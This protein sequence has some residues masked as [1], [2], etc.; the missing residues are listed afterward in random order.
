MY[1]IIIVYRKEEQCRFL[2]Q[3]IFETSSRTHPLTK[4]D[5]LIRP[6]PLKKAVRVQTVKYAEVW[7]PAS[8]K[9]C[10]GLLGDRVLYESRFPA[11]WLLLKGV[12]HTD[13]V[14]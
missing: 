8:D 1:D 9:A 5:H 2:G 10:A 11:F 12:T 3:I 7:L 13:M 4:V 14:R 6:L